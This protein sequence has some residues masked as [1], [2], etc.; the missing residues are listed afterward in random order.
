MSIAPLFTI[1]KMWKQPQ[2]PSIDEWIKQL[3][4]IYTLD[5]DLVIEKKEILWFA[6][7]YMNLENIMPVK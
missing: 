3:G 7:V 6:T 1:T 4:D 5:Y 2:C